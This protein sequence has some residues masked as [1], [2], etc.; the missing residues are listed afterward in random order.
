MDLCRTSACGCSLISEGVTSSFHLPLHVHDWDAM[1]G[2]LKG[3][4]T[5][6]YMYSRPRDEGAKGFRSIQLILCCV[7]WSMCIRLPTLHWH[8]I[9][10]AQV[11]PITANPCPK[12]LSICIYPGTTS[13]ASLFGLG[14]IL[15]LSWHFSGYI[16]R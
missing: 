11:D 8:C 4:P 10:A 7:T 13:Q 12:P 6:V 14:S 2:W 15:W 5:L 16:H 3:Q 1:D 9:R